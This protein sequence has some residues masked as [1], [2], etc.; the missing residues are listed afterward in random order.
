VVGGKS[1]KKDYTFEITKHTLYFHENASIYGLSS[2]ENH[3]LTAGS[4]C[5]VRC[6]HITLKSKKNKHV[7]CYP[8]SSSVSFAYCC[9]LTLPNSINTIRSCDKYVAVGT[10]MGEV[11]VFKE[12][13]CT[14]EECMVRGGDGDSCNEIAFVR[15]GVIVCGFES[16]RLMMYEIIENDELKEKRN[17]TGTP[18]DNTEKN[19]IDNNELSNTIAN[20]SVSEIVMQNDDQAPT[21]N[22][23]VVKKRRIKPSQVTKLLSY[24]LLNVIKPHSLSVQG[25][26]YNTKYNILSSFS[27]DKTMKVF[28]ITNKMT[29]IGKFSDVFA[30]EQEMILFRRYTFSHDNEFL[31]VGGCLGNLLQILHYPFCGTCVLG[32]IGPFEAHVSVI[33]EYGRRN[34]CTLPEKTNYESENAK[35]IKERWHKIINDGCV[36]SEGDDQES[37]STNQPQEN[38]REMIGDMST[39]SGIGNGSEKENAS[40]KFADP[41]MFVSM[42]CLNTKRFDDKKTENSDKNSGR[43]DHIPYNDAEN[44]IIPDPR[45]STE[46]NVSSN[47]DCDSTRTINLEIVNCTSIDEKNDQTCIDCIFNMNN[48]GFRISNIDKLVFFAVKNHLYCMNRTGIVC[49]MENISYKGITDIVSHKNVIFV[50]SVDGLLSSV[51]FLD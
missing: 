44:V 30:D 17:C 6:W 21:N 32:R 7:L 42:S 12:M 47:K 33:Y 5:T 51:R 20:S 29:I 25:L 46:K 23:K 1:M 9:T 24:K 3:L 22:S 2:T 36:Q 15:L 31:F 37:L 48:Y 26:S 14:F 11:Y 41:N 10:T 34:Y 28:Y 35:L 27:K 19:E 38:I 13:G 49:K 4:D 39:M 18:E 40:N 45:L 50:S 8:D 43:V 16:G